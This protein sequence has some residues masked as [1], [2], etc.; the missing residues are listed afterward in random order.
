[1]ERYKSDITT[2]LEGEALKH[3]HIHGGEAYNAQN[4]PGSWF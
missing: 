1:M 4:S 3:D 2:Q